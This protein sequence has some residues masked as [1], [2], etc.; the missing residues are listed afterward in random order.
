M[1]YIISRFGSYFIFCTLAIADGVLNND[2]FKHC[3]GEHKNEN[4]TELVKDLKFYEDIDDHTMYLRRRFVLGAAESMAGRNGSKQDDKALFE[5][6]DDEWEYIWSTMLE[7]G[8]WAVPSIKDDKG[9]SIK[10]NFAPEILIKFIA[11]ELKTHIIVFDLQLNRVQFLSGNHVRRNNVVFDSPLLIYATGGHFQS[12]LQEDHDYFV[13]YAKQLEAENEVS[14]VEYPA[15]NS[16]IGS[17]QI[18]QE[19]SEKGEEKTKQYGKIDVP[20]EKQSGTSSS[21]TRN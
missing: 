21:K 18:S 12:V 13:N 2:A 1:V 5:Y 16:N 14:E 10:A 4:W 17:Q 3:E 11:H 19:S 20:D 6:T 9:N 8:A 7:N 15:M